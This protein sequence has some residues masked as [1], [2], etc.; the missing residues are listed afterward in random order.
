MSVVEHPVST[1]E[2]TM[3]IVMRIQR[4]QQAVEADVEAGDVSPLTAVG[5][6]SKP[7]EFQ[8]TFKVNKLMTS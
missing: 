7:F 6:E 1:Q 3:D 2:A 4:S 5:Y 8:Y